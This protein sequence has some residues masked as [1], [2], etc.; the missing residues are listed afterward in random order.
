MN[1]SPPLVRA[2]RLRSIV[3]A[4]TVLLSAA[5]SYAQIREGVRPDERVD[6]AATSLT[7]TPEY[8]AP[9]ERAR[10]HLNILNRRPGPAPRVEVLFFADGRLLARRYVR[11][12]ALAGATVTANWTPN[13]AG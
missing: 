6:L 9:G 2:T 3:V 7:V 5:T 8:P 10:L 4:L 12:A 1:R 11:V 13:S